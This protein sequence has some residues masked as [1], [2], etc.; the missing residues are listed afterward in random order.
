[1]EFYGYIA[2]AIFGGSYVYLLANHIAHFIEK[3]KASQLRCVTHIG[4]P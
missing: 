3:K 1:M 2:Y 4:K